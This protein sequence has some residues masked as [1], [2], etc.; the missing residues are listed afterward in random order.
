MELRDRVGI[1]EANVLFMN[2]YPTVGPDSGRFIKPSSIGGSSPMF[3]FDVGPE[4]DRQVYLL[5]VLNEG[6]C[7]IAEVHRELEIDIIECLSC[8]TTELVPDDPNLYME[9]NF[10]M[11]QTYKNMDVSPMCMDCA[12]LYLNE[13]GE[14]SLP[15]FLRWL[16]GIARADGSLPH[17]GGRKRVFVR[18][19]LDVMMGR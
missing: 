6:N 13:D 16:S 10:L 12:Q 4:D 7:M 11:G 8:N 2:W 19:I 18:N 15:K 17:F 14:F 9:R 3:R 5:I 1:E